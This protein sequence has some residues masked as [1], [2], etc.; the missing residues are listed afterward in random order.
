MRP[1]LAAVI[2]VVAAVAAALGVAVSRDEDTPITSDDGVAPL[3]VPV[4]T[5]ERV[6][7]T[8]VG[9]TVTTAEGP[10]LT[11]PASGTVT[12]VP[13]DYA[14][15]L[16]SG[17][18]ALVVDDAERV[19]YTA[20]APLWRDVT[21]GARGPDVARAQ[22]LLAA[23]RHFDGTVDGRAGSGTA[24]AIRA[25]N[26]AHGWTSAGTT[27]RLDSLVYLGS[28][29]FTA[30]EVVVR[31]GQVVVPGDV[32]AT[33]PARPL[34]VVVTE[35]QAP[36][37]DSATDPHVLEVAGVTV[38]YVV[39]SGAITDPALVAQIAEALG[40]LTEAAARVRLATPQ[41]VATVPASA[42]LTDPD[43]A[44]CLFT[45]P[46]AAPTPVAPVGGGTTTVQL[47]ADFPATEVLANPRDVLDDP[48]CA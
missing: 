36:V 48:S 45:G 43:G 21:N 19:G 41:P 1:L 23:W 31:P 37:G 38:P 30:V 15:V 2:A 14:S 4:G 5:S 17:T 46:D 7:S 47:P 44:T 35:G 27:L 28:G 20:D 32:L 9:L 40:G 39:G 22:E 13:F 34:T 26:T 11:S 12:A 33:G 3:V 10:V 25:F 42:I 29:P 24:A 6:G 18:V 16:E 8:Q